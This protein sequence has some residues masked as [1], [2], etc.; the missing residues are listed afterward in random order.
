M[1]GPC[2]FSFA[3]T[4]GSQRRTGRLLPMRDRRTLAFLGTGTVNDDPTGR[5]GPRMR[6]RGEVMGGDPAVPVNSAGTLVR[7]GRNELLML[8]DLDER[9]FELYHLKR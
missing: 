3:K 5:Y 8:L 2:G 7:I 4:T 1:R 9:G 6:P